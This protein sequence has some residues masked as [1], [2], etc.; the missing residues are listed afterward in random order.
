MAGAVAPLTWDDAPWMRLTSL[1]QAYYL[2]GVASVI[3]KMIHGKPYYYLAVSARVDG[4]PRI[5]EQRYLGSAEDIEAAMAGATVLPSRTRH[6]GFGDLAATWGVIERLGVV[7]IIDGVLGARRADAGAS[8]G[9][10]VA[11]AAL[12]RVLDPCS[13]LRFADWWAGTAGDHLVKIGGAALDHRRFW[14]AMHVLS[15]TDLREIERRITARAITVF[16]LDTSS[17]ALDMTNFATF[18]DSTNT[19]APIAQR[20]KA[21]QKRTDLR[22]VGLGLVVT[23]DGGIPLLSHAYPGDRPDVTQFGQMIIELAGRHRR[24]RGGDPELTVVFDAGQ[25]SQPN[26]ALL[27]HHRLRYVGSLPPSDHPAL[28]AIPATD[29]QP[30]EEFDGVTALETTLDALGL[31]HRAVLTHSEELHTAQSRGFDQTLAKATRGL[32]DIADT[33][34]RGKAR[35]S[36]ATLETA[37]TRICSPRWV[38]QVLRWE[39]T[40]DTPPDI[41]LTYT[42]DTATRDA[43]EQRLFGKRILITDHTD[44]WTTTE[45]IAGYRSQSDAEFGFRQLKD[46]HVVSFSP[47]HHWTDNHIR[48]HVFYCVLALMIAHLMRRI[49]RR[50]G[51]HLS[52]RELLTHLAGIQE[53]VLL[54]PGTHGRPK[55]RRMITDRTDLQQQLFDTFELNRWAPTS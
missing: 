53:T 32:T 3:S 33:L 15:E 10:Y 16:G 9:T 23:R 29:Y 4:N 7:E 48:V 51:L 25:N 43:L 11:L 18:I 45:V 12:N 47:M 20:G 34:A 52:V 36:R 5:V 30:V 55:A 21:K 38:N 50:A 8:V 1:D 37:I 24:L 26:F 27:D 28:L 44:D 2:N 39:L 22:L 17:L 35:R 13:K 46:P 49:T 42:I 40:G 41:R 19:R 14:D 31:S 54:Y 6:L